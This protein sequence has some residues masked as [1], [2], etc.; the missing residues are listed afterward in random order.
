MNILGCQCYLTL[1]HLCYVQN[2]DRPSSYPEIWV[3][4]NFHLSFCG[5]HFLNA[6]PISFVADF[7]PQA[8]LPPTAQHQSPSDG[9][10]VICRWVGG[11][12]P[13]SKMMIELIEIVIAN[14]F[15]TVNQVFLNGD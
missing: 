14:D 5:C 1:F 13:D 10:P 7:L 3:T 12:Q 4:H 2:G 8:V 9:P 6:S 15:D 11:V